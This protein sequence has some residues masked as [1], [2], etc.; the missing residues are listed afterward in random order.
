MKSK[1]VFLVALITGLASALTPQGA[2]AKADHSQS[3]SVD[4][5]KGQTINAALARQQSGGVEIQVFGVCQEAVVIDQDDVTLL[6]AGTA[7]T[8]V[9]TIDVKGAARANIRGLLIRGVPGAPFNTAEGGINITEGGS[10]NV[11]N[12]RIENTKTR[13]FQIAVGSASIKDVSIVNG[14]AGAFVFRSA[15]VI[16]SGS[17]SAENSLF[18]MSM[19]A[20]GVFAKTADLTFNHNVYGL[21]VQ[22][23][24]SLEHVLGHLTAN[25]NALGVLLAGGGIY[26]Y[27]TF[28]EVRRNSD[29]GIL[30]DE[31]STMSPLVG[32]PGSGPSLIVADNP[33]I[34]ISV[35]RLSDIELIKVVR[36]TGNRV[37]VQVDNS[38]LR[39]ADTVIEG[40]LEANLKLTFG[41]T[42]EFLGSANSVAG[43]VQCDRTVLTRGALACAP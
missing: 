38:L 9:G 16:L 10:A 34:G 31:Q 18:G 33:G 17:V 5:T 20:S 6:G 8:V 21:V 19:L 24:A 4:C 3:F 14:Q 27:S 2:A 1:A 15:G 41:A 11:E 25:D 13:G 36:V 29:Y 22:E 40:N 26:A 23:G 39:M 37:G 30:V 43:G 32:A 12:V 7:P 42:G 28:V 35:E